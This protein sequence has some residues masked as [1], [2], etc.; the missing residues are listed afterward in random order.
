M[1]QR[2]F[3]SNDRSLAGYLAL[4]SLVLF[5]ITLV[6]CGTDVVVGDPNPQTLLDEEG[7]GPTPVPT[8][9]GGFPYEEPPTPVPMGAGGD[10]LAPDGT[11]V[12]TGAGG[13]GLQPDGTP[14]PTG[15]GG[16]GFE[17]DGTAVPTGA[18]GSGLQPDGTLIGSGGLVG[19][20]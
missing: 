18:G 9:A 2:T 17:P 5:P 14:V 19:A 8:G 6:A 16:S 4:G 1:T 20:D 13:S 12:P 11:P 15:A 3:G 7:N 10:L